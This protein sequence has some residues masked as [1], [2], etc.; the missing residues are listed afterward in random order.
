[1]SAETGL[2]LIIAGCG[3]PNKKITKKCAIAEDELGVQKRLS[4]PPPIY[5]CIMAGFF[6][7]GDL[8]FSLWNFM[9]FEGL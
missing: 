5:D 4:P 7:W 6:L 1:M 2:S 8:P 3:P 9:A